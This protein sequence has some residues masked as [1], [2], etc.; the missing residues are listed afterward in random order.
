MSPD[1]SRQ[2]VQTAQRCGAK[3]TKQTKKLA[4]ALAARPP[5]LFSLPLKTP[6]PMRA[7]AGLWANNMALSG[8]GAHM[9]TAAMAVVGSGGA[10]PVR[11]RP[12]ERQT[13][14][15]RKAKKHTI[16]PAPHANRRG[17]AQPPKPRAKP[18]QLGPPSEDLHLYSHSASLSGPQHPWQV[19]HQAGRW[20][21]I[22][23]KRCA[24]GTK[25]VMPQAICVPR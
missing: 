19:S 1:R 2:S 23:L 17:A 5:F 10:W 13:P 24:N 6:L 22:Q 8:G 9:A 20:G 18:Q 25:L 14:K 16:G 15:R 4:G 3:Q 7:R 11:Q 12:P 21:C